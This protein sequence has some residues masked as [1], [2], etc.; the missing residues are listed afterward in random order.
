MATSAVTLE[1]HDS[2]V[3]GKKKKKIERTFNNTPLQDKTK[4]ND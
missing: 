2:V 4:Q 1:Q 3:R